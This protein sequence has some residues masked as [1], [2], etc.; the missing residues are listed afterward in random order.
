MSL[1]QTKVIDQTTVDGDGVVYV[2]EATTIFDGE[3]EITKKYHRWV[4]VPGADVSEMPANVQAICNV[5]WTPEVVAAY[6][7]KMEAQRA[8]AALRQSQSQ[9]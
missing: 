8:E 9:A 6:I 2:R 7:A 1:T 3:Q 4:F 5:T